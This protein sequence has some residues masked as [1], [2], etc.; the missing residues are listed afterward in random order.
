MLLLGAGM[1]SMAAA[2]IMLAVQVR[3]ARRRAALLAQDGRAVASAY[4]ELELARSRAEARSAQLRATLAGITD[5]VMVL[6]ADMRLVQWNDRFPDFTGVPREILRV[7][8]SMQE[9]LRAQAHAGEFGVLED[10]AAIEAEIAQRLTRLAPYRDIGVSERLRPDGRVVELRRSALPDGGFVTLYTDITA[11]RHAEAARAEARRIAEAGVARK[12]QFVA[13]VSHEIRGPLNAVLAGLALLEE[14]G[15]SPAQAQF[16][17]MARLSGEALL[18]LVRDILDMSQMDAGQLALRPAEIALHP[19]LEGV[20]TMLTAQAA[21]HGQ[22]LAVRIDPAVPPTLQADV[23]RLRQVLLNLVGNAIKFSRPG[24]VRLGAEL[25][26]QGDRRLLRLSVR[27]P[28]PAIPADQAA[29]LF[30]PFARL[31]G[32]RAAGTP[33]CGLGLAICARLVALMGGRLGLTSEADGNIFWVE[34][35]LD[36]V[37]AAA[38]QRPPRRANLLLVEDVAS[39]RMLTASLLRREG[40]R[41]DTVESGEEAVRLVASRPF[42]VVLMDIMMPGIDGAEAARRIRALPG[43][44]GRVK[45][46]A[47]TGNVATLTGWQVPPDVMD[48]VLAK[49][50]RPAE[51]YAAVG[52]LVDP[53]QPAAPPESVPAHAKPLIDDARLAD[54]RRGLAPAM[55]ADLVEQCLADIRSRTF[56]LRQALAEGDQA[57]AAAVAHAIAGLAGSYGLSGLEARMRRLMQGHLDAAAI[58]P[59]LDS[60]IARSADMLHELLQLPAA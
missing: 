8:L 25:M 56:R 50:L 47:L 55:F 52:R 14:S 4:A 24:T 18:D 21:A 60:E 17:D 42:D 35:V 16:A 36:T 44:A 59:A 26:A 51:L 9:M 49:P 39:N 41:V 27:D 1:A 54:L 38:A 30:Q 3:T 29:L 11:R 12:A 53:I 43:P 13:M 10:E 33:G 6:D 7:G 46:V 5:G 45:I 2:T 48:G 15:L 22:R 40:H 20:G 23:G 37:P 19:L 57:T 31:E 32:A 58:G 34:L 28:G